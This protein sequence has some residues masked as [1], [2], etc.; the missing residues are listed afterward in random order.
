MYRSRLGHRCRVV[1]G[2]ECADVR[3]GVMP[4]RVCT[5]I[6]SSRVCGTAALALLLVVL[7]WTELYAEG[8]GAAPSFLNKL[9]GRL[10]VLG[11][12]DVFL[13]W[14]DLGALSS[15]Y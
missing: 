10:L 5:L 8:D 4:L 15:C 12:V 2:C 7:R 13:C 6:C 3:N 11:V 9:E 14:V 1:F